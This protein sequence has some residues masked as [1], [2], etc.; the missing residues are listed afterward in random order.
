[1]NRGG[2]IVDVTGYWDGILPVNKI[3]QIA[4]GPSYD[5]PKACKQT[6]KNMRMGQ[7]KKDVTPVR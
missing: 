6:L 1:M 4:L 3:E 5:Y 2:G 7:C